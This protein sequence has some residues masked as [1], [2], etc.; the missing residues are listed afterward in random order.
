M[1][2][3][4]KKAYK[5]EYNK[6]YYKNM[7]PYQKERRRLKNCVNQKKRYHENKI[8]KPELPDNR[9]KRYYLRNIEKIKAYQK[10]YRL[11]QKE[12]QNAN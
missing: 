9:N 7:T 3:E 1:T 5:S 12:K 10:Q 8:D 4:E 6:L 11:K 2:D